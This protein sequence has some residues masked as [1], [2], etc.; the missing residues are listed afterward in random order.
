MN[1]QSDI[2]IYLR[3]CATERAVA[4]AEAVLQCD[5]TA[6]LDGGDLVI[7]SIPGG[8]LVLTPD[9][10]DQAVLGVRF[11]THVRPWATDLACARA[12]ARDLGCTVL[13]DP[14]KG[15]A[16]SQWLEVTAA[17]ERLIEWA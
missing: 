7:Y 16:P 9:V 4:W 14:G 12:A 1:W 11:N 8:A 6:P 5:I 13:V 15:F 17:G 10:E 2:E 3:D